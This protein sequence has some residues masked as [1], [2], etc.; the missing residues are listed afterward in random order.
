MNST[1]VRKT[2]DTLYWLRKAGVLIVIALTITAFPAIRTTPQLLFA[3]YEKLLPNRS[4]IFNESRVAHGG[5]AVLPQRVRAMIALLRDN[6]VTA[7]RYSDAIAPPSDDTTKQRLAE[8]AY[9]IRIN[10]EANYLLLS[11]SEVVAHSCAVV[12]SREGIVLVRC[13]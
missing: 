9:P 5:E 1:R 7:F 8:G 6:Q 2:V 3:F 11:A 4:A 10:V 12:A 13:P